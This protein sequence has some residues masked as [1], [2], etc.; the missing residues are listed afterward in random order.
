MSEEE[1]VCFA[2]A[3]H[4]AMGRRAEAHCTAKLTI[5]RAH[6]LLSQW[7]SQVTAEERVALSN[8]ISALLA[9]VESGEMDAAEQQAAALAAALETLGSTITGRSRDLGSL[10]R[11]LLE[12]IEAGDALLCT[13]QGRLPESETMHL[14]TLLADARTIAGSEYTSLMLNAGRVLADECS[15]LSQRLHS[16]APDWQ[17]LRPR[18]ARAP[19]R[20]LL[21]WGLMLALLL[22]LGCSLVLSSFASNQGS[23]TLEQVVA[24]AQPAVVY[25]EVPHNNGLTYAK[26]S[27]FIIDQNGIIVTNQHVI[28]DGTEIR[29]KLN[30]G[31]SFVASVLCSDAL[32]DIAVL[33]I[34][35]SDLPFVSM[36]NSDKVVKRQ[37]VVAIGNPG[38]I[39]NQVTEGEVILRRLKH[40]GQQ[41]IVATVVTDHGSSGGALLNYDGQVI[42]V[43][44]AG[45]EVEGQKVT[46][47]VPIN[48]IK[49]FLP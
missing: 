40:E 27:G 39:R 41:Y 19:R 34:N 20:P 48:T 10:R 46:L 26:G 28:D 23:L 45:A 24:I 8:Q 43:T 14:R 11:Q 38:D 17:E 44:S 12:Q 25:I 3:G 21:L 31:R 33:K 5:D 30:D 7:G 32:R 42:G 49:A 15:L 2:D 47:A 37:R 6:N 4:S 18:A 1:K 9:R 16:R 13:A 35:C 29:V 36:G 22:T